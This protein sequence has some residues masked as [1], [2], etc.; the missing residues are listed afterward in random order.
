MK[1][2]EKITFLLLGGPEERERNKFLKKK[3]PA[4]I[5]TGSDNTL[6]QFGALIDECH[7]IVTGDTI[8]LHLALSLKK[9]TV[10]Y[11]GPTSSSEV[12]LFDNGEKIHPMWDCFPCY[13]SRCDRSPTCMESLTAEEMASAVRR[14]LN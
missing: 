4:A 9:K 6:R 3:H 5:L 7:L 8:A 13:L 12:H 10:A 2:E 11:F 14:Q 1:K